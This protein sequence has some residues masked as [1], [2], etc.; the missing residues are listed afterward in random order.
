MTYSEAEREQYR[1]A[2]ILRWMPVP[3]SKEDKSD[4]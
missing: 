1:L 3:Q 2:P 4:E